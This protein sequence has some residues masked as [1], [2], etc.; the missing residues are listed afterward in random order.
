MKA[1]AVIVAAGSGTRFGPDGLKQLMTLGNKPVWRWSFD[2]FER[3]PQIS[4]IVVVVPPGQQH[5]FPDAKTTDGGET[6]ANS[7]LNGLNALSIDDD[8]AVL[9]HDAARPGLSAETISNLLEAIETASAAAPA[10]PVYDALKRED[11]T[12]ENVARDKIR[13]VQTPQAFRLGDIKIALSISDPTIVDDLQ[14]IELQGGDVTLIRGTE[15][16]HKITQPEDLDWIKEVLLQTETRTGFGFDVHGFEPGDH[17]TLCGVKIPHTQKLQGHSD[18]DAAWHALTDAILGAIASGDIGDHFPPSD[19]KWKNAES[20]KFLSHANELAKKQGYSIVNADI[21]IV[22]EDPKIKPHRDLMRQATAQC[23][24]VPVDRISVKATTT[25]GLGFTG[26]R[27][28]IAAQANVSL[29]RQVSK[30]D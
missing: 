8:A 4:E 18:A 29:A 14:A 27:E 22:C 26:R 12:L 10:L 20:S 11:T 24:D 17:V 13:R 1:A 23:L 6:R 30:R 21:T 9:I 3:H 25:E 15:R 2:T 16:L 5:H 28:G 7:V 19:N